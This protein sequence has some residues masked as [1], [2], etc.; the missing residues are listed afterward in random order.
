MGAKDAKHI[1]IS[2]NLLGLLAM[3]IT[4]RV[5]DG[6]AGAGPLDGASVEMLIDNLSAVGVSLCGV[7]RDPRARF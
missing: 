5:G 6:G 3:V 1:A 7:S 4:V 2:I